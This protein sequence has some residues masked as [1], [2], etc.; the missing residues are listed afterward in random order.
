MSLAAPYE[1]QLLSA[2]E[3]I[4]P[5]DVSHLM[6]DMAEIPEDFHRGWGEAKPW[7]K[8]QRD[9]FFSGLV[10][11]E[12][13]VKEGLDPKAVWGHL[14]AIQGSFEPKHEHKE[15]AVA[16]LASQW[17]ESVPTYERTDHSG[18]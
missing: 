6:P 12:A 8:F 14:K 2:L 5:T 7:V 10:N 18:R 15:A 17:F 11:V 16:F 4:F 3:T 13:Q 1:P 9:W